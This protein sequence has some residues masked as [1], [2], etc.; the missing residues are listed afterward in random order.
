MKYVKN[1]SEMAICLFVARMFSDQRCDISLGE[2]SNAKFSLS[3]EN[4]LVEI[5]DYLS[6]ISLS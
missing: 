2:W 6:N 4:R 5:V 3:S 1:L